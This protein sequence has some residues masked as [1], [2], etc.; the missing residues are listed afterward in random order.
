M[1]TDEEGDP[2]KSHSPDT[3]T[4]ESKNSSIEPVNEVHSDQ[5]ISDDDDTLVS[6]LESGFH[7]PDRERFEQQE[8]IICKLESDYENEK[9]R[10]MKLELKLA[11]LEKENKLNKDTTMA[12]LNKSQEELTMLQLNHDNAIAE[13]DKTIH[14][15]NSRISEYD[16]RLCLIMSANENGKNNPCNRIYK[17]NHTEK[18]HMK[19]SRRS[20]A[21]IQIKL[22]SN[23][24]CDAGT[25]V[26][27]IRCSCCLKF[28]CENC[29][30]AQIKNLRPIM[31]KCDSLYFLCTSCNNGIEPKNSNMNVSV[32]EKSE[33]QK[34]LT[35]SAES[36]DIMFS[37][38]ESKLERFLDEKLDAKLEAMNKFSET[39]AK[40]VK[41]SKEGVED[42]LEE[43]MVANKTFADSVTNNT[44]AN[45]VSTSPVVSDFRSIINEQRNIELNEAKDKKIRAANVIIHGVTEP[46]SSDKDQCKKFNEDF[47]SDFLQTVGVNVSSKTIYRLGKAD[48]SKNRPIKLITGGESEKDDIMNNLK[49][50]KNVEKYRGISI[51]EDYTI[52]E[53]DM[54][55]A[56]AE[57]AKTKN[58]N[59]PSDSMFTWKVR[60]TPKN[61]LFIKKFRKQ[62]TNKQTVETPAPLLIQL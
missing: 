35:E 38:L 27:M 39:I 37:K 31:E 54:I 19:P 12:L 32:N 4:K 51:T 14:S 25:N 20:N 40:E 8:R 2:A 60:G 57:E 18:F 13:K 58:A 49:K 43:V 42:K 55:R 36:V 26:N 21:N 56:R 1:A 9:S 59:E 52:N 3:D 50:L 23:A 7:Y 22:C 30:G 61:G 17:I 28:M 34:T 24:L 45:K 62:T 46:D 15:Q 16:E 48:S 47:V 41:S 53:R 33:E 29:S 10:R 5:N 11:E 44:N 6:A